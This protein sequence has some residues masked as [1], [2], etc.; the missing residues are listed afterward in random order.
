MKSR[1]LVRSEHLNHE[2]HLFGGDLMT[3]IDTIAF[4]LL[5]QEY[6]DKA[7][8][9][10]AVNIEFEQPASLGDVITFHAQIARVGTTSVQVEVTGTVGDSRIS[11]AMMA[12]V[13]VGPDG[14]KAVINA[15]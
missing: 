9:T 6:P 15:T 8:V 13:N 1:F 7:F 10:R 5:R 11:T 2:G 12:Y 3:E 14:K 4:C